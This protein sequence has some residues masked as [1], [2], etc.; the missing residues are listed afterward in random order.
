MKTNA[1]I[2]SRNPTR[3]G[4][5]KKLVTHLLEH[6]GFTVTSLRIEQW[7]NGHRPDLVARLGRETFTIVLQD[8]K[9]YGRGLNGTARLPAT[10]GAPHASLRTSPETSGPGPNGGISAQAAVGGSAAEPF[11]L[12]W[13]LFQGEDAPHDFDC[14]RVKLYGTKPL[15]E[16]GLPPGRQA[17]PGPLGAHPRCR[18][19]YFYTDS[20]FSRHRDTLDAVVLSRPGR[21]ILCVNSLSPRA[22]RFRASSM[23][24]AFSESLIDPE[25]WEKSHIAF[26]L[27]PG[28]NRRDDTACLEYLRHKYGTGP[29][30]VIPG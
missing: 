3:D 26:I 13:V 25:R 10:T 12:S 18:Q 9:A 30:T 22:A 29:L 20:V 19:C 24:R 14:A 27:D 16:L 5:H 17:S 23:A 1:D 8:R 15:A 2:V 11:H 4:E 28:I 7:C 21:L 6:H